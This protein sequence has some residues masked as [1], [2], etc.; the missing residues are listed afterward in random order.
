[1]EVSDIASCIRA[2]CE[3]FTMFATN[4][5]NTCYP[6]GNCALPP[7]GLDNSCNVYHQDN[8]NLAVLSPFSF[9]TASGG[10]DHYSN[11]QM[12][13]CTDGNLFKPFCISLLPFCMFYTWIRL[14]ITTF[15]GYFIYWNRIKKTID[16]LAENSTNSM[17]DTLKSEIR[18]FHWVLK[19]S[20]WIDFLNALICCFFFKGLQYYASYY[21]PYNAY[22]AQTGKAL[23]GLT[24][25]QDSEVLRY[26]NNLCLY[27]TEPWMMKVAVAAWFIL[28][29]LSLWIQIFAVSS[30]THLESYRYQG[31]NFY[32]KHKHWAMT[33]AVLFSL[34][35]GILLVFHFA[36]SG[37]FGDYKLY[38]KYYSESTLTFWLCFS[39]VFILVL[40]DRYL[41][42]EGFK[43]REKESPNRKDEAT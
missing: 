35:G 18:D 6:N 9:F 14:L 41:A 13:C 43:K 2:A 19:C 34:V 5:A 20:Y 42:Y 7:F 37:D 10:L 40:T 11:L 17:D 31:S 32:T 16:K 15:N 12:C 22:D 1:M 36:K 28:E 38:Y 25:G 30:I 33:W 3:N 27:Q 8:C 4:D 24:P 39:L 26:T 23:S 29:V 21:Y